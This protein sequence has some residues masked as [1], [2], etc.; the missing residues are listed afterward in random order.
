MLSSL[1]QRAVR[2]VSDTPFEGPARWLARSPRVFAPEET[3]AESQSRRYDELT[4]AVMERVLDEDS[5]C[6]DVGAAEGVFT[7]EFLRLAPRGEHVAFE[8]LPCFAKLVQDRYPAVTVHACALSDERGSAPFWHVASD[9]A[10]S[11]LQRDNYQR[12]HVDQPEREEWIEVAVQRLDDLVPLD[13]P[14]RFIKVDVN[15]GELGMFH[16]GLETLRRWKPYV[17]FEH[18]ASAQYY[19]T[20]HEEIYELMVEEAGLSISLLD[21]WLSGEQAL[22]RGRF[23]EVL[24]QA[25]FYFLA[26]PS[27]AARQG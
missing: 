2:L 11:G 13:R 3:W 15:G 9:P 22:S 10:W 14:V 6:F 1:R 20:T 21:G 12:D 26:H 23:L 17:V 27:D 25:V 24:D 19:G 7:G 8:P 4:T 18:G 5:N 16:G